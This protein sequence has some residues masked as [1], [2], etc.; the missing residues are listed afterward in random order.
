MAKHTENPFLGLLFIVS[1]IWL[2]RCIKR[3]RYGVLEVSWSRNHVQYL[4]EYFIAISWIRRIEIFWIRRIDLEF[5]VVSCEVQ[6]RI[7]R[8]FLDGY[9][10]L[11]CQNSFFKCLRS[12]SRMRTS[13]NTQFASKQFW[14]N[15]L[16]SFGFI[17]LSAVISWRICFGAETLIGRVC[18][19]SI[20]DVNG[21]KSRKKNQSAN[22]LESANQKK[23]K[24]N[25]KKSKKSEPK[26]SLASPSKPRSFLRWLPTGRIF[27]LC[28]KTT[29]SGNTKSEFDIS[30]C[31][32]ESASNHQEPTNKGFPSF[33]YFLDRF[34]RLPR[35]N[36]CIH[37]LVVL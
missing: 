29:S 5:F 30:M 19:L 37:P 35:Q 21:M 25:V 18:A 27:D 6:A 36:T 16:S 9:G 33:T 23:H 32:N 26:E 4:P 13:V 7:R 28:R 22:V 34:T 24:A 31:D 10:V 14:E 17:L 20:P 11:R 15:P 3:V 8:I 1:R 2:I 12:S